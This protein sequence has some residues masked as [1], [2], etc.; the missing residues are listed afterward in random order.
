VAVWE[1][2]ETIRWLSDNNLEGRKLL[3]EEL[4]SRHP[5]KWLG[6]DDLKV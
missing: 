5:F 1:A 3:E 6:E 4:E 2:F